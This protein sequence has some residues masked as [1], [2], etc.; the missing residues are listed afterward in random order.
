MKPRRSII[1]DTTIGLVFDAAMVGSVYFLFAGHN[2]PG[3]GFIGG[4]VAGA[5]IALRYIAGGLEE[6]RAV[7]PIRPWVFLALGLALAAGTAIVPLLAG[8]DPLDQT[9]FAWSFELLGK[10][11]FT[12]ATIFDTGVYLIVIGLVLMLF[13]GL[14][15]DWR[16]LAESGGDR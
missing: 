15:E 12:T 13:E 16:E 8:S 14:G 6:V 4:L 5:A 1:L 7:V 9:A 11:K 10:V 3:G 2:R